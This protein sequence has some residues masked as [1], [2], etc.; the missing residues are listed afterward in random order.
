MGASLTLRWLAVLHGTEVPTT[1]PFYLTPRPP[2]LPEKGETLLIGGDRCSR[3]PPRRGLDMVER[4]R[5]TSIPLP[6][7]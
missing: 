1:N 7:S 6:P 5:D 3:F 4:E 2:S